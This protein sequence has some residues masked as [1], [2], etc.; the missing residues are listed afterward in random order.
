MTSATFELLDE[1]VQV[2]RVGSRTEPAAALAWFLINVFRHEPEDVDDA[3]CDGGGDKGIDALVVDDDAGEIL[4]LQSKWRQGP[5]KTQGDADLKA[6]VGAGAYF[7]GPESIDALLDSGPNVEVRNL[8][9][10]QHVREK[11]ALG[12]YAVRLVFITNAPLDASGTDYVAARAGQQPTLEV[13]DRDRLAEV[14]HRTRRADLRTETVVL[15]AAT[16]PTKIELGPKE[17]MAVAVVPALELVKLPGI[18]NRTLFSRNVRLFAGRTSI[19]KD[20]AKTIRDPAEHR[21]FPAYHNGLTLLTDE[22]GVQGSELSL[23]GVGVVNG[24]QS[25][26]TLF[27]NQDALT[28]DLRL[29]VKVVEVAKDNTVADKVTHRSNNQNSVT[30]RDQRSSDP[31]MRSLQTA[32]QETFGSSFGLQIRV[33]EKPDADRVLEN[34]LAAQLIMA[35]LLSEPWSAVRKVRLFDQE[36]RR[37]FNRSLTPHRLFLLWLIDDVLAGVRSDLRP[38]LRASYASVRFTLCHLL[39]RVLRESEPGRL[40]LDRPERYLPGR[41]DAT[42][43]ALTAI[44]RDVVESVNFYIQA[45]TEENDLFDS[46]TVFKSKAGVG[47]LEHEVLRHA[48]RQAARDPEYLF[49]VTPV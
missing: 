48:R 18:K 44:A 35:V 40:L 16:P 19:N 9:A 22:L 17:H 43:T 26:I 28:D 38:E 47:K 33:G 10:R 37:I 29:L 7:V 32:V 30:L 6:L 36:F 1:E 2:Q 25:L 45:E 39:G 23:S 27:E 24:C 3:I 8:I 13:W 31:V 41:Q 12:T 15:T 46:K 49:T 4:V 42:A 20:L 11:L 21:L 34:S 14:A 5:G